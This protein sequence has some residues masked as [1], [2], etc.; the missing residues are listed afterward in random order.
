M[1]AL[2]PSS[3]AAT[4]VRSSRQVLQMPT[5]NE[6][7][8]VG[9]EARGTASLPP[10]FGVPTSVGQY[11]MYPY[12]Y[13]GMWQVPPYGVPPRMGVWGGSSSGRPDAVLPTQLPSA[14]GH[15]YGAVGG[16]NPALP[17]SGYPYA[18]Y[19][20]GDVNSGFGGR[21]GGGGVGSPARARLVTG[22]P[23]GNAGGTHGAGMAPP[24]AIAGPPLPM[25][26]DYGPYDVPGGYGGGYGGGSGGADGSG[27]FPWLQAPAAVPLPNIGTGAFGSDAVSVDGRFMPPYASY[28]PHGVASGMVDVAGTV[29]RAVAA[30]RASGGAQPGGRVAMPALSSKASTTGASKPEPVLLPNGKRVYV[31][32]YCAFQSPA[33]ASIEGHER[34]V[35]TPARVWRRVL[36]PVVD[37]FFLLPFTAYFSR[38]SCSRLEDLR[39]LI[40]AI[41]PLSYSVTVCCGCM[42]LCLSPLSWPAHWREAVRVSV[43]QLHGG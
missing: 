4:G 13:P 25:A 27:V 23:H 36:A 3:T 7:G 30:A 32:R 26:Y 31:C 21:V 2:D 29:G 11:P 14:A 43:L 33:A 10:S 37:F 24:H 17:Y 18:D 5:S 34:R 19:V 6:S 22:A 9:G 39:G 35:G 16:S 15:G 1:A 12:M 8:G 40:C 20:G 42:A 41:T 28:P 38:R